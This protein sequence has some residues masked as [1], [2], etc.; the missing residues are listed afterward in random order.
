MTTTIHAYAAHKAGGKLE[1]FSYEP[2]PLGPDEVEI[3]VRYCGICHSDLSMLENE[4]RMSAYPL[5]PGHEV[6]GE[7][8]AVG[9]HVRH[10]RPGQTVGLGWSSGS[11][12]GCTACLAG[13]HQLCAHGESTI[14]GRPGGFADRVRCHWVW[15]IPLPDRVEPRS[16]GPLF[17][18]GIT[19]FNPIV[20]CAVR[21]TDRV[22]VVGVGGLGHMAV[23]FLNKWGCEVTA[24]TTTP[25]KAEEARAMGA[26]HVVG[27]RDDAALDRL[28]GAFQFLL[29][30]INRPLPWERYLNLLAMRGR[31]HVVGGI[32]EPMAIPVFSLLGRQ[33]SVSASPT[34]SPATTALMLDFCARHGIA[35]HIEAFPMSRVNEAM[36]HLRA[37]KARYRIVLENDLATCG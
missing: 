26:H 14:V 24:F 5:V 3:S 28:A 13:D 22:G 37:G 27:T 15:A 6:I 23:Q 29:V 32:L 10:V 8:A 9:A 30:T 33:R 2:G 4:W 20:Q 1:P 17:C 31:L 16:A 35:P 34:G 7:V 18:G 12:M 21:P 36:D 11:C 19:V 25:T